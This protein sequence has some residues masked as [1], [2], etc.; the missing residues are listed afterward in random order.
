MPHSGHVGC[1]RGETAR[2]PGPF[3]FMET[4]SRFVCREGK[5]FSK[6]W[7]SS[8]SIRATAKSGCRVGMLRDSG[9]ATHRPNRMV[10]RPIE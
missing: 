8:N 9:S 4:G 6:N 10:D 5:A 3:I 1:R 7:H 2:H